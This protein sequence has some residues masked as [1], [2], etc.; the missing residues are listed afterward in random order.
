M[1]T[2]ETSPALI[3]RPSRRTTEESH[4]S[5]VKPFDIVI[6]GGNG[7][8]AIRKADAYERLL[9]PHR[10]GVCLCD[11]LVPCLRDRLPASGFREAF[12]DKGRMSGDTAAIPTQVVPARWTGLLGAAEAL[13]VVAV[14][15]PVI[16]LTFLI[17]TGTLVGMLWGATAPRYRESPSSVLAR[18]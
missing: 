15:V 4:V 8:L 2:P 10:G 11:G 17:A 16:A 7:D 9:R 3:R 6:Y 12:T 14:F 5:E 1:K 18:C 13:H